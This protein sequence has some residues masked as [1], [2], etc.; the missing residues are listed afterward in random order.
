MY[1][2]NGCSKHMTGGKKKFVNLLL[3]QEGHVTYR[4]TI[5]V[6]ILGRGT[7]GDKNTF[8]IND[9]LLV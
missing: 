7:V 8:V 2:D 9:V 6:K 3:K 5:K 4:E 1:L